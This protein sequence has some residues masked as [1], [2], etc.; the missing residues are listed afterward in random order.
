MTVALVTTLDEADTIGQLVSGLLEV[1]PRVLVVDDPRS[2]DNTER[3]AAA[4]GADTLV[5]TDAHGIGPGLLAGFRYLRGEDVVTIDA[6]GSHDPYAI[7]DLVSQAGD[8]V[9]GSRF[10]PGGLHHGNPRRARLS[11]LYSRLCRARTG[12]D[13][14]DWT[15]GFRRYTAAAVRQV[16]SRPPTATM[17]GFQPQALVSCLDAGFTATEWPIVYI[18]GRSSM[19]TRVAREAVGA[20]RG[21]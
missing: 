10:V 17:H 7:P 2:T 4:F 6:G 19:N 5:D 3:V 21:L 9:I 18:A 8:I 1:V 11:R 13:I 20:L 12:Y 14:K 15:S 16:L